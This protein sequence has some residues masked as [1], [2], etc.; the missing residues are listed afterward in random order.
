MYISHTVSYAGCT[1]IGKREMDTGGS[2][3]ED[4]I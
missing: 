2:T 1:Y 4:K 3:Y